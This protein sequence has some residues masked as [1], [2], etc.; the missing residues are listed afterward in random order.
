VSPT[1]RSASAVYVISVAARLCNAHPQTLRAYEQAGLVTPAR[2]RGGI[3][4][5]SDADIAVL[6][7]ILELTA[8]GINL[9]G[10]GRIIA[11]ER[12]VL[13]LRTRLAERDAPP[14]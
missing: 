11:L 6:V 1:A 12:E 10:V 9:V 2:T 13:R 8:Q 5:Y 3:R 7:R 14:R 4:L